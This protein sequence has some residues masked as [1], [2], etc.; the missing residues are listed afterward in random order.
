MRTLRGVLIVAILVAPA[1]AAAADPACVTECDKTL[2]ACRAKADADADACR[3]K[4]HEP[5]NQ[6]CPCDQ[7][8][9]AAHFACLQE[10]QRCTAEADR[11]A[12]RCPDGSAAK[13]QCAA[14]HRRCLRHCAADG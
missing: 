5:C 9:G 2:D 10:C 6:W 14:A 4:A 8:I 3:K 1:L 12:A 7:F 13:A 11:D